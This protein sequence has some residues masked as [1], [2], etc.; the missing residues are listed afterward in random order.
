MRRTITW[1]E[2]ILFI[3]IV[4]SL[5]YG[6]HKGYEYLTDKISIEIKILEK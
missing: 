4:P 1:A 5:F 6:G 3:I 2:L